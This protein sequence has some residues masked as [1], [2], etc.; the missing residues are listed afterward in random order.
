MAGSALFPCP[1]TLG[2]PVAPRNFYQ[3]LGREGDRVAPHE[4]SAR[5][6]GN[7]PSGRSLVRKASRWD[8]LRC[9]GKFELQVCHQ[10]LNPKT[11]PI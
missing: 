10:H 6:G 7:S 11:V 8:I 3:G 9:S 1:A 5:T 2:M 4:Q